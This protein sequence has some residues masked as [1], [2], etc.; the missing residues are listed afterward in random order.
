MVMN[1]GIE[2]KVY[3]FRLEENLMD[4]VKEISLEQNRSV[5]NFVET[6]L[7]EYVNMYQVKLPEKGK[8][9]KNPQ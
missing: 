9:D 2:K 1:M 8:S 3:S 7:K 4:I 6:T 5:S